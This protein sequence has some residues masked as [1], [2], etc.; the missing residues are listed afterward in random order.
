MLSLSGCGSRDDAG[1][2]GGSAPLTAATLGVQSVRP[3]AEY[4]AEPRYANAGTEQGMRLLTQCRAC[5]TLESGAPHLLGPNLQGFF[6]RRAGTA[7][8]YDYS[9]ALAEA[10]FIWTPRALDAWLANPGRFLP[11]NAMA[12]A[13]LRQV[14][15]RDALISVLLR[16]TSNNSESSVG[17]GAA[18]NE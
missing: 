7:P 1:G 2:T 8:G 3:I 16:Q 11:G 14:D 15:D 9:R 10:Q 4:L 18:A 12:Y 17:A 13:G 5:H 6:G